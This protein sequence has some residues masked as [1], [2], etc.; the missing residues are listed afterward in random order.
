MGKNVKI[1]LY[2]NSRTKE[3]VLKKYGDY[4]LDN[5][6]VSC[7]TEENLETCEYFLEAEFLIDNDGLYTCFHEDAVLKVLMDYGYELFSI[8]N[9]RKTLSRVVVF[10][11]QIT[12]TESICTW[13]D[14]V[15]PEGRNGLSALNH[16]GENAIGL[17]NLEFSSD[18]AEE[19]TAF[20]V[21]KRLYDAIH[22]EDNC[23]L[24]RWGGEVKRRGY[25]L[26]IDKKLGQDKGFQIR[27]KR[28]LTGIEAQTNID[29]IVTRIKPIGFNGITIEGYV[30]SPLI[31]DYKYVRTQIIKYDK[32]KIRADVE[33]ESSEESDVLIFETLEEAQNKLTELA[34]LEYASMVDILHA[35]YTINFVD[36]SQTEEYKNYIEAEHVELGDTITVIEE[37]HNISIKVR[38]IKK[39]YDVLKQRTIEIEVSNEAKISESP[40]ID[41]IET[42]LSS[43]VEEIG[44]NSILYAKKTD[45][46]GI[47][48]RVTSLEGDNDSFKNLVNGNIRSINIDI[49]N[50][51]KIYMEDKYKNLRLAF[52]ELD[53]KI[54]SLRDTVIEGT[55]D[56][57]VSQVAS[58]TAEISGI[59]NDISTINEEVYITDA[60]G[61]SVSLKDDYMATVLRVDANEE[62]IQALRTDLGDIN[63]NLNKT[64]QDMDENL[65]GMIGDNANNIKTLENNIQG[66]SDS[67]KGLT[68][69][70]S[71]NEINIT[72]LQ[73]SVAS[74]DSEVDTLTS[75]FNLHVETAEGDIESLQEECKKNAENIAVTDTELSLV[76]KDIEENVKTEITLI[77]EDIVLVKENITSVETDISLVKTDIENIKND[78]SNINNLILA[79]NR[80][81]DALSE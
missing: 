68:S 21:N 39:K 55:L 52:N 6:C 50:S 59:K 36:L 2:N 3:E 57:V 40:K 63:T 10:A 13:L 81:I 45:L 31:D 65:K 11:R 49:I 69:R 47:D 17:H 60:S 75:D 27:R 14:D 5:I 35:T 53:T 71:A 70:I 54:E 80:K 41:E 51:E 1:Q 8:V 79:L 56:N 15:R 44:N 32:V 48:E 58:N 18:I 26:T 9:V 30:D 22:I 73:D 12:I 66:Y 23:F 33:D 62:E 28:N 46:Q 43:V 29:S 74:L 78:I 42:K 72:S 20:Y 61:N 25:L 76:K 37:K 4:I 16:M 38:A 67:I 7:T 64:I 24:N 77:K 34:L 19:N